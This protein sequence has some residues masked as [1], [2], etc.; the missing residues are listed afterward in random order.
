M[1]SQKLHPEQ[2]LTVSHPLPGEH[3]RLYSSPGSVFALA[4]PS[5]PHARSS[6]TAGLIAI[7][8]LQAVHQLTGIDAEGAGDAQNVM[9]GEVA[10]SALD[11]AEVRPMDVAG[12]SQLFLGQATLLPESAHTSAKL[13]GSARDRRFRRR[14][15]HPPIPYVSSLT[16]QRSCIPRLCILLELNSQGGGHHGRLLRIRHTSHQTRSA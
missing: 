15:M 4:R 10:P 13:S 16:I 8:L 9:Q 2:K 3:C 7:E 14:G 5:P 12:G 11:L 1:T 6:L